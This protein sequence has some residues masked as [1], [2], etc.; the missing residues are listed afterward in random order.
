MTAGRVHAVTQQVRLPTIAAV[1]RAK[2]VQ[3]GCARSG[4]RVLNGAGGTARP[5]SAFPQ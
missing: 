3:E 4:A 2:G 1:R 5:A